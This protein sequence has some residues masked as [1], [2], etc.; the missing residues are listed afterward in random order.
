[1]APTEG[2]Q[3]KPS[4]EGVAEACPAFA[5]GCPYA[6]CDCVVE[7][8]RKQE[9]AEDGGL[10][11]AFDD[12]CPFRAAADME[13]L[14]IKLQKLPPSHAGNDLNSATPLP[15]KIEHETGPAHAAVLE[16]LQRVHQASQNVRTSVGGDCP[17]FMSECP[18]K[19][20]VTSSQTP[21]ATALETRSWGVII[22][23]QAL[24][25]DSDF[26][27]GEEP[28]PGAVDR[29]END[30]SESEGLATKLKEGTKEAH[31]AAETVHF[32]AEFIKG[33]VPKEVYGQMVVN[34]YYVYKALEEALDTCAE[35]ELIDPLYFPEELNRSETLALDADYFCGPGWRQDL[36][37][38]DVTLEYVDRLQNIAKETPELLVPHAYT[39]YLGDLSG[40]QILR[41]AAV[42]GMR[43]PDDGSGVQFFIFKRIRDYKT[44]KAMYRA[45]LDSLP[46]DVETADR[47]VV[48]A[49][50]AFGLNT[51]MFQELDKRMGFEA[52]SVPVPALPVPPG[53]PEAA[54]SAAAAALTAACP[55]AALAASGVPMP[56]EHP[57]MNALISKTKQK[58]KQKKSSSF[59]ACRRR[60]DSIS[61]K[62]VA[63]A[64]GVALWATA[65]AW[66][67]GTG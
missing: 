63:N 52:P 51:R 61:A 39:R 4:L 21:L 64:V 43:L 7:W 56:A 9:L 66:A 55:F 32:V 50:V 15:E 19:G 58:S 46:A 3:Q 23:D 13:S 1:M 44:F 14:K 22:K 67:F 41:K 54:A 25:K 62:H 42:R 60:C 57:D 11:P 2:G 48:E 45:R 59:S 28:V 20:C 26:N 8:L 24:R 37:P 35:H 30:S 34:L 40:G 10:C 65:V 53:M 18:F 38:S 27:E 17:V 36:G 16:M 6:N 49:N 47:M 29:A 33:K 31:K 12:G 5:G